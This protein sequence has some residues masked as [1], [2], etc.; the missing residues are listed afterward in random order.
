M[1]YP[2]G[3]LS[4]WAYFDG[5]YYLGVAESGYE[6][7][8]PAYFPLYLLLVCGVA[9]LIDSPI[10]RGALSTVGVSV[11]LAA[12]LGALYF[13]YRISEE[14]WGVRAAEGAVLSLYFFSTS[15]FFKAVYTESLFPVLSAGAVCT[16]C[17]NVCYYLTRLQLRMAPF[18]EDNEELHG[19][20][21]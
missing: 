6:D 19:A 13:V 9:T 8:S 18:T 3:T 15:F 16:Q 12:F 5:E 7:Y 1:R 10:F 4:I 14:G 21:P 11:S 2:F 17:G 20:A